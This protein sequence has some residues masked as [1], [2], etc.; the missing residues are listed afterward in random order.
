MGQRAG[1]EQDAGE[2]I[3]CGGT[4]PIDQRA[5]VIALTTI[6]DCP[7]QGGC[8]RDLIVQLGQG[9]LAVDLWLAL[10][11][12]IEVWPA[13]YQDAHYATHARLR[14]IVGN[15]GKRAAAR[16][17]L[18]F[19]HAQAAS[20]SASLGASKRSKYRPLPRFAS[21]VSVSATK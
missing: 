20:S 8:G 12:A 3:V 16:L 2:T 15:D 6:D 14:R 9:R 1:I 10:S 13:Q 4:D 5:F 19:C 21:G 7:A 18:G 17:S 11:E